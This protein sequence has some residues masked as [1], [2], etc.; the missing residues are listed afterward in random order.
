MYVLHRVSC[1]ESSTVCSASCVLRCTSNIVSL[2]TCVL[3][4][5]FLFML[6]TACIPCPVFCIICPE[7]CVLCCA[8]SIVRTVLCALRCTWQ[9]VTIVQGIY[10][11][12]ILIVIGI[13]LKFSLP[14]LLGY[15]THYILR[16]LK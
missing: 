3:C 2:V 8:K 16:I 7:L 6:L 4:Y 15:R 10:L 11:G 1:I 9:K 14:K 12:F 5:I 13:C